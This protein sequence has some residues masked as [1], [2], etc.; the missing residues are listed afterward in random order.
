M[1]KTIN[2][3]LM[4]Y[5]DEST[6]TEYILYTEDDMEEQRLRLESALADATALSNSSKKEDRDKGKFQIEAANA[7]LKAI[8]D[9]KKTAKEFEKVAIKKRFEVEKPTY[10]SYLEA[11]HEASTYDYE[12]GSNRLDEDKLMQILL[13]ACIKNMSKEE[14]EELPPHVFKYV[15]DRLNKSIW[16]DPTRLPF[17]PKRVVIS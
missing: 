14:I 4:I 8:E 11:K 6:G 5:E 2:I 10:G 17:L 12:L 7:G 13:P 15:W 1:S 9:L 3:D 16:P